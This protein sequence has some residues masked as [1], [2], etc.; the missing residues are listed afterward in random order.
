MSKL[1]L[2]YQYCNFKKE[3][4]FSTF[5][6]SQTMRQ[7]FIFSTLFFFWGNSFAQR[8]EINNAT[9]L[10][11]LN[12]S[13]SFAKEHCGIENIDSIFE[14]DF[15]PYV[16][17]DGKILLTPVKKGDRAWN[18]VK[19]C[20]IEDSL[21]YYGDFNYEATLAMNYQL[22]RTNWLLTDLNCLIDISNDMQRFNQE[23]KYGSIGDQYSQKTNPPFWAWFIFTV[24]LILYTV[25][26]L[27]MR[28]FYRKN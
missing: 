20:S 22:T 19:E 24:F 17:L 25:Y 26:R 4:V 18:I 5:L 11:G 10:A 13:I 27:K 12:R 7:I 3:V 23:V 14:G 9:I 8:M 2:L 28:V 21:K 15:F 16:R 1:T 6:N